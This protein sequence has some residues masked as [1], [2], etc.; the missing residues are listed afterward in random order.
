M[1]LAPACG[2]VEAGLPGEGRDS[3]KSAVSRLSRLNRRPHR[4]RKRCTAP[5]L[6]AVQ[7]SGHRHRSE[8]V[9]ATTAPHCSAS[10]ESGHRDQARCAS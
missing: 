1:H 3:L 5:G 9:A 8:L 4:A 7:Y 10:S 2:A 6:D